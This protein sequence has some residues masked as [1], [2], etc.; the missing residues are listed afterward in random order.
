MRVTLKTDY[1][2]RALVELASRPEDEWVSADRLARAQGIP[3]RFLLN[4]LSELRRADL[5]RSQRGVDGGYRLAREAWAI[6]LADVI[7]VVDGPLAS[8]GEL[9]PDE[10]DYPESSAHLQDVWVAVRSALRGVLEK[11]TIAD[12]RDGRLPA[13]TKR[14]AAADDAWLPR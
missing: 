1:A 7:R 8:V 12:V 9:R 13:T 3:V 5:V 6:P 2:I 14:L 11:T 10:L 4:I